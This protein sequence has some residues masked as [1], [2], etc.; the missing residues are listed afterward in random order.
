VVLIGYFASIEDA[1]FKTFEA[2]SS[3][4]REDY[5]FGYTIDADVAKVMEAVVPKVILYKTFDELKNL[6]TG[7]ITAESLDTFAYFHSL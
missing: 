4:H 7:D 6:M 1:A 5:V 2:Y 3:A